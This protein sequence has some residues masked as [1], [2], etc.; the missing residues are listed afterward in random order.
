MRVLRYTA[1]L[2]AALFLQGCATSSVFNP[3]PLQAQSFREA[4]NT[5]NEQAALSKLESKRNSADKVLYLL[6]RGRIAQLAGDY[7]ASKA[8]FETVIDLMAE[9][10]EQARISLSDIGSKSASLITNDNA[11]PYQARAYER[12]MLH[13]YQLWL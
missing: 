13:Q 10:D 8:D 7:T 4:L 12:I 5:G 6:E 1:F 11:I 3:Y 2:V 9:Y